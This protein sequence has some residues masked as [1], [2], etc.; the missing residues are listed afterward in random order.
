M[1]SFHDPRGEK[2]QSEEAYEL[3]CDVTANEGQGIT[4]GLL[5]N[6]FPDSENFLHR[7]CVV[8]SSPNLE[9]HWPANLEK[10]LG[11]HWPSHHN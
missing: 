8:K 11:L 2:P 6:G 1:I 3:S 5:A 9:N 7:Q 4:L 10:C